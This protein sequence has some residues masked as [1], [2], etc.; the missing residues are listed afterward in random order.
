MITIPKFTKSYICIATLFVSVM[1]ANAQNN[2][3]RKELLMEQVG[4]RSISSV[5]TVEIVFE[6]GQKGPY[7]KHPCP[8]VGYII[9]GCCLLQVEGKPARILRAGDAFFEPADTPITHF[10][11]YSENQPLTFLATYLLN[12]E[13]SLI[14]LLPF[15]NQHKPNP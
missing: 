12:G 7:H 13:V 10:D 15:S 9:S 11:N 6:A 3:H 2:A 14:E 5:R 4:N 1:S 8:V